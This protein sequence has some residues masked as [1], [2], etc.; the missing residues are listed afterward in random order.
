M[1]VSLSTE[2]DAV[3]TML[4][5]IGESPV[6]T[7]DQ[8]GVVD[9]TLAL[10]ILTETSRDVQARSWHFNTERAYTLH[11]QAFAP[12]YIYAPANV[13]W[14]DASDESLDIVVR[15]DKLYDKARHSFEFDGPV[16][17]DM[18]LMLAFAELPQA[19]RSYI[20]IRAA[21]IFQH[22][23]VGSEALHDFHERDEFQALVALRRAE[24]S[25]SDRNLLTDSYDVSRVL[26]RRPRSW[27]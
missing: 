26:D 4:Q 3:N 14:L 6:N 11:P 16:K 27:R 7:L 5:S 24:N 18:T 1:A 2:L 10:T 25:R 15:G 23:L 12:F 9:A 22:R 8:S 13:L 17:V 19:A 21:R 20:T